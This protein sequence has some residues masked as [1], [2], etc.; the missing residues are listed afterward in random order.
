LIN[1]L[2]YK[3]S[4]IYQFKSYILPIYRELQNEIEQFTKHCLKSNMTCFKERKS[5]ITITMHKDHARLFLTSNFFDRSN[6]FWHLSDISSCSKDRKIEKKKPL[7][8]DTRDGIHY[9]LIMI[10]SKTLYI[11]SK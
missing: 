11:S 4:S 6:K 1:S 8:T 10:T 5:S 9:D 3:H 7:P 2:N